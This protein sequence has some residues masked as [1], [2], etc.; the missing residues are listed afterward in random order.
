MRASPASPT[1]LNTDTFELARELISRRS[2]TPENAGCLEL[3]SGHLEPLGFTCERIDSNGV[4]NLWARRGERSPLV[5]LA[6][7]VDVVPTGPAEQ[8]A[9]DPFVPTVRD[10]TL[11][12]RG[13]SDMK[14]SIAAFVVAVREFVTEHPQ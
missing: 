12:G 11:Y 3:V 9:S 4:S 14:T 5:C 6:G 8:W 7:H 10:G 2:V 1:P 13:A